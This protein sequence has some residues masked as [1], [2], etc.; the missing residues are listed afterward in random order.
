MA[1]MNTMEWAKKD[2]SWVW[3]R[4]LKSSKIC[5]LEVNIQAEPSQHLP[6][7]WRRNHKEV[8]T[9]AVSS[10]TQQSE[11]AFSHTKKN[12]WTHLLPRVVRQSRW[13][14]LCLSLGPCRCH[15]LLVIN[16]FL[17]EDNPAAFLKLHSWLRKHIHAATSY[18]KWRLP[19]S[20]EGG[21][22]RKQLTEFLARN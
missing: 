2:Q 6:P 21:S 15:S 18:K 20:D 8:H 12:H 1:K 10:A 11:L 14:G 17:H 19:K 4:N 3:S 22:S 16:L 9:P 5:C 7:A 13:R